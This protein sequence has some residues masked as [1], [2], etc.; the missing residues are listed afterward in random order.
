MGSEFIIYGGHDCAYCEAAL[1]LLDKN[2]LTYDYI[3]IREDIDSTEYLRDMGYTRIPQIW[4]KGVYV[5]GF[6]ELTQELGV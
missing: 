6:T 5:G 4:R 1:V 2:E 3:N